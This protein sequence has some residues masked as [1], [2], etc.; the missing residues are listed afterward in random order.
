MAGPGGLRRVPANPAGPARRSGEPQ[1]AAPDVRARLFEPLVTTKARGVGLGLA[2][3][4]KLVERNGGTIRLAE[5]DR[6]GGACFEV[7][8]G[9]AGG[10]DA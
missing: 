5:V 4:R 7:R 10:E 2:L 9:T 6:P 1:A 8:L 3:C